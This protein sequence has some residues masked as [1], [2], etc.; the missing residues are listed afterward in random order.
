METIEK[1]IR[2]N[3]LETLVRSKKE[4]LLPREAAVKM[5]FSRLN[6]AMTDRGT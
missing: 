4:N 1:K 3:T 6:K 5:A 2:T